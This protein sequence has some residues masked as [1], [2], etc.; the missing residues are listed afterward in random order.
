MSADT[1]YLRKELY[2]L[3]QKDSTIFEFLQLGSL[4]GVWYWDVTRPEFEWM[5][6]RFWTLLGYNPEEK[7]HLASEWQDLIHPDDLQTALTN[8]QA[9]A[10][11]PSHPYDQ[12]VRYRHVNGSTVWV[13]CRGIM[14]RDSEGKPFRMLGAHTDLTEFKQTEE[15]LRA[16]TEQLEAALAT[17]IRLEG[18][19]PICSFCKKIKETGGEWTELEEYMSHRSNVTFSHALCPACTR[20][21]YPAYADK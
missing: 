8:F 21:H 1:N 2:E 9:H 12:V 19:L 17:I 3:L 7:Q 6:P 15:K 11:D 13:R 16:K 10:A 14:I 5:S 4:D 20:K 18:M